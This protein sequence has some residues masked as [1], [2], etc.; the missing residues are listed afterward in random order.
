[1]AY[2]NADLQKAAQKR[3]YL[4]NRRKIRQQHRIYWLTYTRPTLDPK[5]KAKEDRLYY[6][7]HRSKILKQVS[8][9]RRRNK[10]KLNEY[11]RNYNRRH[12]EKPKSYKRRFDRRHPGRQRRLKL[13]W[14]RKNRKLLVQRLRQ[15]RQTDPHFNI[16][17]RLR[18]R[19]RAAI[20][21][22]NALKRG[23]FRLLVGCSREKLIHHI[24]SLFLP[25]MSWGN[26]SRWH[27]DHI[28]PCV[29]FDLSKLSEQR[30]CFHY[31]NLQPLWRKANQKK[32]KKIR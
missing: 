17:C 3:Y 28:D 19:L 13:A 24:E 15:R 2:R 18:K 16:L 25:G 22:Q 27:I 5:V 12:P 31:S 1:M 29:S 14:E 21:A 23:D 7:R 11:H 9:Y 6:L 30:K 10:V 20:K 4:K 26:R 32:G 8:Q